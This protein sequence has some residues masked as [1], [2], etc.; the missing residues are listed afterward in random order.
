MFNFANPNP[1]VLESRA[2]TSYEAISLEPC[3]DH[4]PGICFVCK[5]KD[6]KIFNCEFCPNSEHWSCV[7]SKVIIRVPE[8]DDAFMG[9]SIKR[10]SI[11]TVLPKSKEQCGKTNIDYD[12]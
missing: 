5:D 8:P 2:S 10:S 7:Q 11:S 4:H 1:I 6:K 9:S 12:G 3:S